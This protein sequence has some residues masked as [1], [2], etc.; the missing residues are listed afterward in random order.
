MYDNFRFRTNIIVKISHP[1]CM[2]WLDDGYP[3]V[4]LDLVGR[5]SSLNLFHNLG[6]IPRLGF[7]SKEILAGLIDRNVKWLK[8]TDPI[9][10]NRYHLSGGIPHNLFHGVRPLCFKHVANQQ[11]WLS[12]NVLEMYW[13]VRE[14]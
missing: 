3:R 12:F 11:P 10:R 7:V 14:F 2:K 1:L 5:F 8:I 4:D 9:I 13:N 6:R